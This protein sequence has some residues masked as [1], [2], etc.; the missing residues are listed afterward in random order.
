MQQR[1]IEI[2]QGLIPELISG[3]STL[4]VLQE[5]SKRQEL[6]TLK[7]SSGIINFITTKGFT[8][9]ELFVVVLIIG[10][11][12]AVAVPQYQRVVEHN[13]AME[14]FT[15]LRAIAHAQQI[16]YLQNGEYARTFSQLDFSLPKNYTGNKQVISGVATDTKSNA[17]WSI[18]IIFEGKGRRVEMNQWTGPYQGAGLSW[19]MVRGS[20]E[21]MHRFVCEERKWMTPFLKKAGDF[22]EKIMHAQ[23]AEESPGERIYWL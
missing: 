18:Q 1:K 23:Y 10:I 20:G 3:S 17:K 15:L 16:Y 13:R 6:K 4:P 2:E 19:R 5:T 9:I 11:L 21:S 7:T 14:A 22:C 12:A 8:L